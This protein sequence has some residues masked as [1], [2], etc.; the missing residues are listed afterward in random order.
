MSFPG[1]RGYRGMSD[2]EQQVRDLVERWVTAVHTGDLATVL[3]NHADDIVMF[4]VPPPHDGVRGIDAY[5][6]TWPPFLRWQASGAV[7]EIV[8]LDVTAGDDVAFAHALLRCATPDHLERNPGQRLRLTIGLRKEDGRWVVSHEHH[9][10]ADTSASDEAAEGEV[11]A[12][13]DG[14]ST[15]TAARDLDGLMATIDADVVSYEHV[16]PLRYVGA[17][18]VREVCRAGLDAPGDVTLDLPDVTVAVAGD[19]AVVWGLDRVTVDGSP[20]WSR[21]TR[22]FR[23]GNGRWTMVHQHLS[24]PMDPA[25]GH[26]ATDLTP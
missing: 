13:L 3:E 23:R 2:N 20:T 25:T 9:S 22:V 21:G 1:T 4:D 8:E 15:D 17:D 14:W 24:F 6:E 26:A 5:R 18:D 11:R 10:F 16:T 12:V 7:F 19:L